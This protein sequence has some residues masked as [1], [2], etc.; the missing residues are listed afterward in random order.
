MLLWTRDVQRR[1]FAEMAEE[2]A[3]SARQNTPLRLQFRLLALPL[4]RR[5]DA[6]ALTLAVLTHEHSKRLRRFLWERL[7][8]LRAGHVAKLVGLCAEWMAFM[9]VTHV[10]A[11]WAL[12]AVE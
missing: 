4:L 9:L 11:Q 3:L 6:A 7:R 8:R 5:V 12:R 10:V 2:L 1:L